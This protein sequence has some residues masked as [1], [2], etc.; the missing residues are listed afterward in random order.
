MDGTSFLILVSIAITVLKIACH[1]FNYASIVDG[2]LG[3]KSK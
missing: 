2:F 3:I 1:V